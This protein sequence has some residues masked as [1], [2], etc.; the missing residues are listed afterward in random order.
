[1]ITTTESI[2]MKYLL[3]LLLPL[4]V[5]A[6]EKQERIDF[7]KSVMWGYGQHAE[8]RINSYQDSPVTDC[9]QIVP[10]MTDSVR[11]LIYPTD[12]LTNPCLIPS[13]NHVVG[14]YKAVVWTGPGN[15]KWQYGT[16]A[17]TRFEGQHGS[18][19]MIGVNAQGSGQWP[20]PNNH[21]DSELVEIVGGKH[22]FFMG[23]T[24]HR[25]TDECVTAYQFPA[26]SVVDK[27]TFIHNKVTESLSASIWGSQWETDHSNIIH[28]TVGYNYYSNLQAGRSPALAHNA[29]LHIVCNY[30]EGYWEDGIT[31]RQNAQAR[32]RSNALYPNVPSIN[33]GGVIAQGAVGGVPGPHGLINSAGDRVKELSQYPLIYNT[34]QNNHPNPSPSDL[35]FNPFNEYSYRRLC[36][37]TFQSIKDYAINNSGSEWMNVKW[38]QR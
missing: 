19:V 14:K 26:G 17:S 25:M 28:A 21:V 35:R 8:N 33:A 20:I 16:T 13:G 30:A 36:G 7:V 34:H 31:I 38:L 1:M 9:S 5:F 15:V 22:Y 32:S 2:R 10:Y 29:N 12:Q 6:D 23:N 3:L 18:L 27:V 37:S 4:T 11:R 24:C